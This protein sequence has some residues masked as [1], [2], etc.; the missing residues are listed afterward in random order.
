VK[1]YIRKSYFDEEW[2]KE[3]DPLIEIQ[4]GWIRGPDYR[5]IARISAR[6][7]DMIFTQ[8]V[9]YEFPDLGMPTLLIIGREDRTA[10]G[11]GRVP[12][13]VART[14]GRYDQL[15]ERAAKRIPNAQLVELEGVGH[16]PHYEVFDRYYRALRT[17]LRSEE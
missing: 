13:T 16:V 7:Y 5:T 17:F 10:L 2:K 8:P 12:D 3:Y 6:T 4:A 1:Q 11:T 9:L 14:L 15:G